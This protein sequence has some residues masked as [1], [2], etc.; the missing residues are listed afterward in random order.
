MNK[1]NMWKLNYCKFFIALYIQQIQMTL[2][3]VQYKVHC[4]ILFYKIIWS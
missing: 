4:V 1:K 3:E 2:S